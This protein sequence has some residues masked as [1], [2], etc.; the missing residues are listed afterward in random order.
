MK[1]VILFAQCFACFN[2]GYRFCLYRLDKKSR[3]KE[4]K[5]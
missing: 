5:K 3:I 4:D 1:I 2:A